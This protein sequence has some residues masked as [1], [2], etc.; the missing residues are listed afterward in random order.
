MSVFFFSD[1]GSDDAALQD[2]LRQ[3]AAFGPALTVAT[4]GS[5][6]SMAWDGR[7]FYSAGIVPCRVVDTM[8]AGDSFIAGFLLS[9]LQGQPVDAC[10]TAGAR[11]AAVTIGYRGAW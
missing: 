11:N 9:W 10:L 4:R 5:R 8:G 1:D 2:R 6:G 7:R 3:L